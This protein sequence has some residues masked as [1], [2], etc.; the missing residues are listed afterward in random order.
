MNLGI[1][2]NIFHRLDRGSA[3]YSYKPEILHTIYL[4]LFKP[5]MNLIEAFPKKDRRL[6]A[7]DEVWK[8]LPS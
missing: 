4:G 8:A 5:M 2:Q 3:S 7:F 6:Q 1:G